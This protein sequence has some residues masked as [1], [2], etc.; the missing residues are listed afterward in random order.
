[1]ELHALNKTVFGSLGDSEITTAQYVIER[2]GCGLSCK[3]SHTVRFLRNILV[4]GLLGNGVGSGHKIV[5]LD[6]ALAVG[7]N[8]LIYSVTDNSELDTINLAVFGSLDDLGAA[9][10]DLQLDKRLHRVG[11]RCRIGY[12]VLNTAV[13]TV[14]I[15]SPNKNAAAG[16]ASACRDS[17]I[18]RRSVIGRDSQLI[19]GNREIETGCTGREGELRKNIIGICQFGNILT[20]VPFQ[21][22]GGCLAGALTHKARIL[23]MALNAGNNAV[24]IR[25]NFTFQRMIRANDG[26]NSVFTARAHMIKVH[27]TLTNNGF[28]YEKLGSDCMS[29]LITIG[30]GFPRSR[31]VSLI[32]VLHDSA[33]QNLNVVRL[34]G[35]V[36]LA[37]I[38]VPEV[39]TKT[40]IGVTHI[41]RNTGLNAVADFSV[42]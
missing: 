2:N 25:V 31:D 1:M 21:F 33:E 5:D 30:L 11:N 29:H 39:F 15:I 37:G 16:H 38:I 10:A 41:S 36:V 26:L 32:A 42:V 20:A 9:I 22:N 23:N 4:V 34:D 28:P 13:G 3:N 7:S 14:L 8:G 35:V 18:T 19:S 17:H 12:G 27:I 40:G 24:V 6:F